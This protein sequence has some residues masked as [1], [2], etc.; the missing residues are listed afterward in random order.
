ARIAALPALSANGSVQ[1]APLA[2]WQYSTLFEPSVPPATKGAAD[3]FPDE[4]D[5]ALVQNNPPS[6]TTLSLHPTLQSGRGG[7]HGIMQDSVEAIGI[8]RNI[9]ENL[10][11]NLG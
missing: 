9:Y 6:D 10:D 1:T 5:Y 2:G 7:Q 8:W 4:T 11:I 3:L